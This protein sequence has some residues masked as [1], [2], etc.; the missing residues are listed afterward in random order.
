MWSQLE[1][2]NNIKPMSTSL[3]LS[4]RMSKNDKRICSDCSDCGSTKLPYSHPEIN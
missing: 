2:N 1:N 3:L 4:I